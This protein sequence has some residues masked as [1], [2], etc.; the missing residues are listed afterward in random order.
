VSSDVVKQV[1]DLV[2]RKAGT[3][4]DLI[5]PNVRIL[6]DLGIDGD[7]AD[8]LLRELSERCQIDLTSFEFSRYFRSEP[9]LLS[10]F[11]FLPSQRKERLQNKVPL[12]VSDLIRAANTGR[13]APNV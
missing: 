1:F 8:D 3:T 12:T 10:L 9:S 2:A 7:D 6:H 11:W 13:I 5:G 4:A